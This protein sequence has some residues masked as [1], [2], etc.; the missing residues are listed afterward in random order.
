MNLLSLLKILIEKM[1]VEKCLYAINGNGLAPGKRMNF[2][3]M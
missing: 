3:I 2:F 1:V